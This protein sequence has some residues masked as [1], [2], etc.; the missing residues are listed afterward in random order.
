MKKN[1][2]LSILFI[3][4]SIFTPLLYSGNILI[5]PDS[6]SSGFN[7][8]ENGC[9]QQHITVT[10][11]GNAPEAATYLWNFGDAVILSGAEQGPYVVK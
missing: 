2:L 1:I 11:T 7:M 3:G 10:Y 9:V 6:L 4:F 8:P 5:S